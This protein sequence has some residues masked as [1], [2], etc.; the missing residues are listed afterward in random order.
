MVGHTT[1]KDHI[2]ESRIFNARIVFCMAVVVLLIGV[3]VTRMINLQIVQHAQL[4]TKSD[5]N[6]IHLQPLPPTRGL[7]YDTQ[8][9]L[10]AQNKPSY[11]LVLIKERIEDLDSSIALLRES[12][13]ITDEQIA[14]YRQQARQSRPFE[15]V[16]LKYRLSEDEIA[17]IAVNEHRLPGV[18]VQAQLVRYYPKG[19]NFAHSLGYVGSINERELKRLNP[20]QYRGTRSIGKIG[21]ERFYEEQLL[22]KAGYQEVETN[23]RGR[24]L[25]VIDR[26]NP[27]PGSDI[28]LYL[29]SQLQQA[30]IDALGDR[31]G[32]V[33][34][35][36]PKTGGILAMVSTPSYDPNLFV[37]GISSKDY[38]QL[39]EDVNRPLYNRASL[40]EYPPASTIKPM[41]ALAGL[42]TGVT[43]TGYSVFD[44]GWYQLPG[45]KRRYRNW[46]RGGHGKV[47]MQWAIM[48]SND[49]YFYDLA[50][51]LGIDNMH[52]YL[53]AF[54]LGRK[55]GLDVSEERPGLMPSREWKQGARGTPWYPGETLIT[56]IGQGFMLAT[57]LQLAASTVVLANR[58][59]WVRPRLMKDAVPPIPPSNKPPIEDVQLEKEE[60][61]DVAIE[62]M[63]KVVHHRRG[64]ANYRIGRDLQYQFAG[65]TGTA[66]VVGIKQDEKYDADKLSKRNHDHGLFLGFAPIEDP[67]IAIAVVV[68]NGGGG[69]SAAAPVARLVLDAYL[70]PRINADASTAEVKQ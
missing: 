44:P 7:I 32:A 61:W 19:A 29:D 25:R 26:E 46:K 31:R 24:V 63:R 23:A 45:E 4:S 21:V 58:G 6:R 53:S 10:L 36:D 59:R 14:K 28:T 41:V 8:G 51:K 15:A 18:E 56:G 64:T 35:I 5:E 62:A 12:L 30:A 2:S 54:G 37:T 22:G 69:S 20:D 50:L 68:E 43:H 1:L 17:R 34:A 60:Y 65:K 27:E 42:D 9:D 49:T 40:G 55:V 3:L 39:R 11:T 16:P 47:N 66:Q 70:L 33:V 57:P 67:Q 13:S 52:Q 38:N 48:L